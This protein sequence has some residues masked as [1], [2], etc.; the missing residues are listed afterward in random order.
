[1]EKNQI[2]VQK[3]VAKDPLGSAMRDFFYEGLDFPIQVTINGRRDDDMLPSLFFRNYQKMRGYERLALKL[4]KGSVLDVG[5]AVGCHSLLLQKRGLDVTALEKSPL[6]AE[7]ARN[8]GVDRV[9]CDDVFHVRG[10]QFNTILLLMN[11]LGMGGTEEGT[12][13]LLKHLK[14]MLAPKGCIYGDST[15]IL[16]KTMD[17]K[18]VFGQGHDYHGQ[19]KFKLKYR[20][21][22]AEPFPW[23]YLD[24]A[25][26]A[27]LC[28]KAGLKCQIIHRDPDFHYLAKITSV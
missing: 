14:K 4:C 22:S 19:V 16:Y 11:G 9:I 1:M 7:I 18:G 10:I 26:L 6:A 15:D 5:A 12:L 27:E 3:S 8:R 24:P 13:K 2:N 17:V 21:I 28:D 25:L 20:G 23:I